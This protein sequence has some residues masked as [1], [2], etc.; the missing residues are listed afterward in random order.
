MEY[1]A[2]SLVTGL[3][4]F[5]QQAIVKL[6]SRKFLAGVVAYAPAPLRYK[7]VRLVSFRY[8][9]PF[10]KLFENNNNNNNNDDDNNNLNSNHDNRT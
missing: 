3:R 7:Y 6:P 4:S 10:S 1:I 8:F 2:D 9:A 5:T